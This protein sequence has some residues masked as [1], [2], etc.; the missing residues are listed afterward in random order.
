MDGATFRGWVVTAVSA[1]V[2][3][4]LTLAGLHALISVLGAA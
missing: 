3:L 4:G 1:S 2:V